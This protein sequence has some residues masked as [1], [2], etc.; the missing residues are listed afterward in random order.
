MRLS[1]AVHCAQTSKKKEKKIDMENSNGTVIQDRN[2]GKIHKAR[3]QHT[4]SQQYGSTHSER[5]PFHQLLTSWFCCE[6]C[7]NMTWY[8]SRLFSR[9]LVYQ[10]SC[11]CLVSSQTRH[12]TISLPW[13]SRFSRADALGYIWIESWT[14]ELQWIAAYLPIRYC[15]DTW[16]TI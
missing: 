16:I 15:P 6:T 2:W 10:I 8:S 12:T 7:C 13:A 4:M 3:H 14:S 1:A 11:R 5:L 9:V